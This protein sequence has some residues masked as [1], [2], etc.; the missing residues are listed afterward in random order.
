[1]LDQD[2]SLA[3]SSTP[4]GVSAIL[5]ACYHGHGDLAAEL[6]RA[7]DGPEIFEAAAI[8][9]GPR[10]D[11]LLDDDPSRAQAYSADG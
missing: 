9:L 7:H 6:A 3:R 4:D 11:R 10:L 1:M 8:G 2:P 5:L